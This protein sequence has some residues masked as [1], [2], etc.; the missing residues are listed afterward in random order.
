MSTL[1]RILEKY[2][3]EGFV[4]V[5]GFDDAIIGVSSRGNLAYSIKKCVEILVKEGFS[6]DDAVEHLY[7]EIDAQ[8]LGKDR[9]IFIET[10]L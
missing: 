1:S 9:P 8:Y 10:I 7:G 4:K 6:Y 2:P 3:D 5:E